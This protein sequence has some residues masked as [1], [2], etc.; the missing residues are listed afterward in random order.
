MYQKSKPALFV[1]FGDGWHLSYYDVFPSNGKL[2]RGYRGQVLTS[3]RHPGSVCLEYFYISDE[4]RFQGV[5]SDERLSRRVVEYI[6][7]YYGK[8]LTN[9]ATFANYLTTGEFVECEREKRFVVVTQ[10]MRPYTLASR[11]DVGDMVCIL[12]ANRRRLQSRKS[13]LSRLMRQAQAQQRRANTFTATIPMRAR[14]LTSADV[15]IL[16]HSPVVDDCHFMVCIGHRNG[17]PIWLFQ[18]GMLEPGGDKWRFYITIGAE[19]PY[20]HGTPILAYIKKRRD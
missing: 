5:V 20:P 14:S 17:E 4:M 8:A 19:N 9:C 15:S 2:V 10:G 16:C 11:V 18:M 7:S 3:I 12:Y 6:D 13:S 1:Q